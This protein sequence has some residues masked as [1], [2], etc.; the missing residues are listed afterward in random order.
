MSGWLCASVAGVLKSSPAAVQRWQQ[1]CERA[2]SDCASRVEA[3]A[4]RLPS[5][6]ALRR[7][8]V[9]TLFTAAGEIAFTDG[10]E[11]HRYLG[12]FEPGRLHLLWRR[13]REREEFLGVDDASGQQSVFDRPQLFKA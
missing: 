10:T 11:D 8:G 13:G 6:R 1:E 3:I 4:L 7:G 2:G 9:L 5:A 12:L